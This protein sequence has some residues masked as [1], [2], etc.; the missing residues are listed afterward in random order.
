LHLRGVRPDPA[1]REAMLRRFELD[2]TKRA[3]TYSKGNRQKIALV[4]AFSADVDLLVLDEPTSGLD[5]LMAAV[6]EQSVREAVDRGTSVLLSSHILA[7]VEALCDTVTIIR[8][9]RVVQQGTLTELRHLTRS[10]V[11]VRIGGDPG[12][13][14]ALPGVHDLTSEAGVVRFSVDDAA[15]GS[16]AAALAGLDPHGL[17]IAPP[18]LEE[19][20]LRE[21]GDELAALEHGRDDG[22]DDGRDDG[23]AATRRSV[24]GRRRAG[25]RWSA[26]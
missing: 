7:E 2:P 26:R 8:A 5:P 6:F 1:R 13:L 3:A 18:S 22:A 11:S 14:A 4:A 23:S 9:G 24:A 15:V 16:L 19:L 20:F 12:A 21:Y 17:T 10:S 25:T